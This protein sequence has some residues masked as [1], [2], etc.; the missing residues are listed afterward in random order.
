M[1]TNY[2]NKIICGDSLDVL[3]SIP[4]ESIDSIITD[5]PYGY[6]FMGKDWDKAV[7]S[8]AL[9]KECLRVLKSGAFC[10]I[11]SAPRQDV[12]ARMSIN[13]EDAGF[14]TDFT[15]VYWTYA[16]GFPKAVDIGKKVDIRLNRKRKV[17]GHKTS[18][19]GSGKTYAFTDNNKGANVVEVTAPA[20]SQAK[21][22]DG[23]YA[24]FQPKPALEVVIVC[25]KPLSEKTYVG[26]ALKNKKGITWLQNCRVPRTGRPEGSFP[27][28]LLVSDSVLDTK[29]KELNPHSRYFDVDIW[30]AQFV[31]SSKPSKKEK[32]LGG[33]NSHPTVKPLVLMRYLVT[34]S[35][36][37][38][39]LILDP[40]VG[41]GTTAVAA[42]ELNRKYCGI[43]LNSEYC[44][45]TKKRLEACITIKKRTN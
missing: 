40:F 12:L 20:S 9:W 22:L 32:N 2:R 14:K 10:F 30:N 11:M 16:T 33:L 4:D 38:G 6:S 23:S 8:V 1:K 41:S 18:G 39:D 15:S 35:S 7:P 44:N 19:L 26:Q 34:L 21:E 31:V 42:K 5:P 24:G 17:V 45:L 43:D 25:M 37:K 13:L 29:D 28:N 27:S 36:Q 3:R